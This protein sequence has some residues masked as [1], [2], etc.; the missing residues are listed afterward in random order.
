MLVGLVQMSDTLNVNMQDVQEDMDN[1]APFRPRKL[2]PSARRFSKRKVH[3]QKRRS[4]ALQ[5]KQENAKRQTTL[6]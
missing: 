5:K 3:R 2:R 6:T 1:N 4:S